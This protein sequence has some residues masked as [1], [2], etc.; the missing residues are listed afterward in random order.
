[1]EATMAHPM[2]NP[3]DNPGESAAD[4]AK[5][6]TDAKEP[7]MDAAKLT[8]ELFRLTLECVRIQAE[9]TKLENENRKIERETSKL[10]REN[11][12]IAQETRKLERE[13]EKI[14]EET[15][16]LMA[17]DI[18]VLPAG[19]GW[20]SNPAA[21]ASGPG[22]A[23]KRR[24]STRA[25]RAQRDKVELLILGRGAQIRERNRLGMTRAKLR[26]LCMLR[27]AFDLQRDR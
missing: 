7:D 22:S 21:A 18:H 19:D 20:Q 1:M 13:N 4:K 5:H 6:Q 23:R 12:K 2:D 25:L 8:A 27:R 9:T 10:E 26:R 11:E 17:T 15:R 3:M 24:P 16:K 14:V